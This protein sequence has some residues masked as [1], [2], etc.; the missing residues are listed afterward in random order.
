MDMNRNGWIWMDMDGHGHGWTWMD[1][2]ERRWTQIDADRY[3]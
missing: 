1:I 2:D 3:T